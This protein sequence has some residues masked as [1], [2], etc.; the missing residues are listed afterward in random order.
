MRKPP[1]EV[2]SLKELE[3]AVKSHKARL[4]FVTHGESTGGTLQ[5]LEGLAP[6]CH[7]YGCLLA[8]DAVVSIAVDP[9]FVDRW[10]ID[11]VNAGTQKAIGAPPGM[12]LLTFS[13]RAEKRMREQKKR[14]PYYL[15]LLPQGVYFDCFDGESR[16]YH[17]TFSA[18]MLSAVREALAQICEEGLIPMWQRHKSNAEYFWKRL[19][20]IG[21]TSFVEKRENRFHGVTC[22]NVPQG[23]DQ[24]DFLR[25][26]KQK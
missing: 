24:M 25:Y 3:E 26:V 9:L 8:V 15:D 12:C 17:Y 5:Q 6:V 23:I 11:A 13:P 1:G 19:D 16:T 10:E 18:N 4:L 2:Y 21:L 14:P 22:V 7:K 20:E